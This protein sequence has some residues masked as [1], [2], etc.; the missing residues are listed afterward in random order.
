MR[1]ASLLEAFESTAENVLCFMVNKSGNE[2]SRPLC[3]CGLIRRMRSRAPRTCA[4]RKS[5]SMKIEGWSESDLKV[6]SLP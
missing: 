4:I 6:F 1:V 2:F 3:A 5:G